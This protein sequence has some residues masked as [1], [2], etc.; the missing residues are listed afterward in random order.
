MIGT[1]AILLAGALSLFALAVL[2]EWLI[3]GSDDD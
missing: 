1:L 3:E 2:A